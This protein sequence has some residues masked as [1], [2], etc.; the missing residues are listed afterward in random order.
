MNR[1]LSLAA[2]VLMALW[3]TVGFSQ[4]RQKDI[5]EE[6]CPDWE[7]M[8]VMPDKDIKA[9]LQDYKNMLQMFIDELPTQARIDTKM[10]EAKI[11]DHCSAV[12]A[13]PAE[14]RALFAPD[15]EKMNDLF[16]ELL[17]RKNEYSPPF[18]TFNALPETK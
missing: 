8:T 12:A 5:F 17:R 4:D 13:L 10:I 1:V 14:E 7:Q 6:V 2:G 9:T 3:P 16:E 18:K 11:H 15:I